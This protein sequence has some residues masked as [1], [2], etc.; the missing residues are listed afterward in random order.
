MKSLINLK[1]TEEFWVKWSLPIVMQYSDI[2]LK[3]K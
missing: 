2:R 1:E 3:M